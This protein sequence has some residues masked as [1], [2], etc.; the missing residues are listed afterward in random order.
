MGSAASKFSKIVSQADHW[1]KA[2]LAL[3]HQCR[4]IEEPLVREEAPFSFIDVSELESAVEDASN[5]ISVEIDEAAKLR[6][7]LEKV[8]RW[9]QQVALIAPKRSKRN[10]RSLQRKLNFSDLKFLIAESERLP[11]DTKDDVERLKMQLSIVETWR[12]EAACELECIV[13]GFKR[14]QAHVS[15]VY[16]EANQFKVE[17]YPE[18]ISIKQDMMVNWP[19]TSDALDARDAEVNSVSDADGEDLMTGSGSSVDVFR[20]IKKLHEGSKDVCVVTSEGKIIDLLETVATWS[21]RSLKY[22]SSPRE[23]F[24]KRYFGS[25]DRFL[26][27][28]EELCS[29]AGQTLESDFESVEAMMC[30]SWGQFVSDQL[31]R[32]NVLKKEREYFKDWCRAANTVLAHKKKLNPEKLSDLVEKSRRFP[33]SK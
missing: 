6:T 1:Y 14:L 28:G 32:L 11:I 10:V 23:I 24:E 21:I 9:R 16:N 29:K 17:F 12:S 22:L 8:K 31:I 33:A 25:Y 26:E 13:D 30:S 5:T 20:R 7:V 2:H 3:L 27:E 4:V 18:E 19:T 15:V